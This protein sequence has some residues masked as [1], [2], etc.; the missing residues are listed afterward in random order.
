M[1]DTATRDLARLALESHDW[2]K[3]YEL[4]TSLSEREDLTGRDLE[5]LGQAAWWSAHP[6]ESIELFAQ[7]C[8]AYEAE[9]TPRRAA[10]VALRLAFEYA[11]R[12]DSALWNGWVQRAG[13]LLADQPEGVEHGY[14]ELAHARSAFNRGALDEGAQHVDTAH[15]IGTRFNDQ[16]LMALGRTLQGASLVFA[17]EIQRG[18]ALVDEGANQAVSGELDPY[19]AG[20]IYCMTIGVCRA[21]ADFRRAAEWTEAVTRWCERQSI[22]AFPGV[23]R[24]Q[25]AEI[26]R[27][28]GELP[29]AEDEAREA[30]A[31]LLTFGRLPQAGAGSYEVGEVRLR[32]GDLDGAQEAFE[33][34][35][36]L[37]REPNPGLALV[38]LARGQVRAARAAIGAALADANDPLDR[39]LLLAARVEIALAAQDTTDAHQAADEIREIAATVDAPILHATWYRALGA[40][41]T[42]EGDHQGA[43][44]ALREA[45][46]RW[47]E[48]DA[49][50]EA[51][52]ARRWLAVAYRSA[53]DEGSAAMELRAASAAFRHLGASAE[54]ERCEELLRGASESGRRVTRT[55]MFTDIVGSTDLVQAIGDEA[56]EDVL[57]WHDETLRSLIGQHRGEVVHTT[58]DGF[59][60]SFVDPGTAIDCA[61]D[62]QRR[63]VEHRRRNGFAPQIRIGLH[64][65]NATAVGE[66]YAGLDVHEAARV[67]AVAQGGEVLATESTVASMTLAPLAKDSREVT[68]KGIAEP[69]R[70]VTI[71]WRAGN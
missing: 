28:R 63:L 34:A 64:E 67:G 8:A 47:I 12:V 18:L 46:R 36:E 39:T 37:G 60:A 23:C 10:F 61:V 27:L 21:V 56:W 7:S 9:G 11:D 5:G 20:S 59:F 62:I 65:G 29:E 42:D 17:S 51:A 26:K 66:D 22:T 41:L 33:R 71:D 45:V 48:I 31:E 52:Q 40:T 3:A 14:L 38:H 30:M 13:R 35:H 43:I 4:F 57:R 50:F 49:P 2:L 32:L 44:T 25:R 68:L 6:D 15:A 54:S 1:S 53:G 24:V 16:N 58:G 69:V 70:V 55:F 19:A